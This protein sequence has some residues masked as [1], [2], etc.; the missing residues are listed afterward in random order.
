MNTFKNLAEYNKHWGFQA[1]L[2]KDFDIQKVHRSSD[3]YFAPMQSSAQ[4]FFSL[5]V[6][7]DLEIE[8][9]NGFSKFRPK[10]PFVCTRVPHQIFSWQVKKG[11]VNGWILTFTENFLIK[12]RLLNNIIQDFPFLRADNAGPFEVDN[13]NLPQLHL[14]FNTINNEYHSSAPDQLEMIASQ[15]YTLLMILNRLFPE[16]KARTEVVKLKESEMILFE[17]YLALIA[18]SSPHSENCKA[19][20]VSHFAEILSVHPNYLNAVVKNVSGCNALCFI[21]ERIL[22]VAKTYLVQSNL[23]IKEISYELSFNEPT[24][25]GA[26]FKKYIGLTPVQFRKKVKL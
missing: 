12:H 13:K 10:S 23:S 26:F 19:A 18:Q 14:I 25:F 1:P 7:E 11:P 8:I 20:T 3:S 17:K 6:Y 9:K 21:H 2:S 4:R 24:H 5:S 22:N 15:L 16:A